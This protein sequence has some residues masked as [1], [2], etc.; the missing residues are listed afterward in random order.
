MNWMLLILSKSSSFPAPVV[1]TG[2]CACSYRVSVG[3]ARHTEGQVENKGLKIIDI[4]Q[5]CDS[6]KHLQSAFRKLRDMCTPGKDS[7]CCVEGP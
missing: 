1:I 5:K 7:P 4:L 2:V 3:M 6:I